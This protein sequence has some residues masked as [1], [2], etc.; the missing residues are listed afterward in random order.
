M[1]VRQAGQADFE[2]LGEVMFAAVRGGSSAYSE[3]QREAWMPE[4]RKGADWSARLSPQFILLGEECAVVQGFMTLTGEG[5]LDC[6]FIR[7]E[8]RGSGLFRM[9]F[10]GIERHAR[11]LELGRIWAHVSLT[12]QPAAT[13]LGMRAVEE[14]EVELRG[15]LFRRTVMEKMLEP[16]G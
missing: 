12:A 3:D 9:L 4:P 15:Q 10:E 8:A 14:E 6:A 5:Y 1:I 13:A 2:A 16:A 7:P 11:A